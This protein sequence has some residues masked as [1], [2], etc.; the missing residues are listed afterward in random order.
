M[1]ARHAPPGRTGP[2]LELRSAIDAATP[3][4]IIAVTV[5]PWTRWVMVAAST[6]AG[7]GPSCA[8]GAG[9]CARRTSATART[10]AAVVEPPPGPRS[11]SAAVGRVASQVR[12]TPSDVTTSMPYFVRTSCTRRQG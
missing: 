2:A 5:Q 12:R 1:R 8:A 9:T 3:S 10:S 11:P 4:T 7:G 6:V